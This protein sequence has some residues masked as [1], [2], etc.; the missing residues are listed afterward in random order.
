MSSKSKLVIINQIAK[1]LIILSKKYKEK[2]LTDLTPFIVLIILITIFGILSNSFLTLSN[3]ITIAR[4]LAIPLIISI[5]I[6]FVILSG[7][8]DLSIDG[9]MALTGVIVSLLVSNLQNK[10]N[11]GIWGIIIALGVGTLIGFLN[12]LIYVKAKIP[13][14]L[15]T[16]GSS[17]ITAG[18]AI[19]LYR[20]FPVKI[21]DIWFRSLALNDFI[22]IP[23]IT[24]ISFLVFLIGFFLERF[25][26]FGSYAF[27]IGAGERIPKLS[28]INIDKYK[29]FY[30]TWA[31]LCMA[32]GG[33]L[34]VARIGSGSVL[35]GSGNM[36][37]AITAVV[38]GGTVLTGGVG[39]VVN[40]LCGAL[41][42]TVLNNGMIHLGIN[43]FYQFAIQG[44]TIVIACAFFIRRFKLIVNK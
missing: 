32:L 25:T 7:G 9:V 3:V 12:G 20:G 1:M 5:G 18:I 13:S 22:G 8:I 24:I 28:G 23:I 34:N 6:T 17:N 41:A 15:L 21:T 36:F 14:F 29:I 31:G 27:A 16:L 43:P 38:L 4:Q 11:L 44:L 2:L 40:T 35:V 10:L 42:I 33:I 39:G 37:P 19:I 30:F 26:L